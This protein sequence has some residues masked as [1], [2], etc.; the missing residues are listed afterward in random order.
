M[1][2]EDQKINISLQSKIDKTTLKAK[3]MDLQVGFFG[4]FFGSEENAPNNICGS[5]AIIFAITSCVI[6]VWPTR[7]E[8]SEYLSHIIPVV[9]TILG[10]LFGKNKR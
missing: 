3:K 1:S 9:T 6:C 10:Y 5:V 7:I 8:P 4:K 2:N